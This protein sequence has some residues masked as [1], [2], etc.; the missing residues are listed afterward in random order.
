[1]EIKELNEE[2]S[3]YIKEENVES[4]NEAVD[5]TDDMLNSIDIANMVIL[6]DLGFKVEVRE[7]DGG[8]CFNANGLDNIFHPYRPTDHEASKE[9]LTELVGRCGEVL[10]QALDKAEDEIIGIFNERSF[11]K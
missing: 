6:S 1:M 8:V 5:D 3:K 7:L 4:K 11:R 10:R 2:L 9:E